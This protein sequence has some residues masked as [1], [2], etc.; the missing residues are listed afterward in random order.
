M[1]AAVSARSTFML[2]LTVGDCCYLLDPDPDSCCCP[3]CVRE[4]LV[5]CER[6]RTSEPSTRSLR[7]RSHV[8]MEKVYIKSAVEA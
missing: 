6:G 2:V 3:C 5:V 7:T 1:T 4:M 8:M